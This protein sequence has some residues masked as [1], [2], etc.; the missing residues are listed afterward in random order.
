[1]KKLNLTNYITEKP[2]QTLNG[3][4][5]FFVIFLPD[6]AEWPLLPSREYRI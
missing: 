3:R 4:R 6:K 5:D 1:M 2:R